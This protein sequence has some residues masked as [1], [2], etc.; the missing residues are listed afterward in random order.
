MIHMCKIKIFSLL[1]TGVTLLT[2]PSCSEE[3]AYG[4]TQDDSTYI[5]FGKPE[6]SLFGI[7]SRSGMENSLD[8]DFCV[9]GYCAPRDVANNKVTNWNNAQ[10][11]WV[12]KSP[13][14]IPNIF[15]KQRVERNGK[16][17]L[18]NGQL[19]SWETYAGLDPLQVKYTF[20]SY[21]PH[22]GGLFTM[23]TRND[24]SNEATA[25][26]MGVPVLTFNMPFRDTGSA[27]PT[28]RLNIG[29][30]KDAMIAAVFDRTRSQG[31]VDF[32]FEHLLS[33]FRFKINNYTNLLLQINRVELSGS[34]FRSADIDFSETTIARPKAT[35]EYSGTFVILD[36]DGTPQQIASQSESGDFLGASDE[37]S[38]EGVTLMLL[39][40]INADN[41]K[42][43]NYLGPGTAPTLVLDYTLYNEQNN[44]VV[45]DYKNVTTSFN[46]ANP[47]AGVRYTVNLNFV[48]NE[49]ILVFMPEGDSWE[50]DKDND[51]IIN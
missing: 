37:N 50:G 26:S 44:T 18:D 11:G 23:K 39:A 3:P 34:F 35:G 19:R 24:K 43:Y 33:A 36:G 47:S 38:H 14:V 20:I 42:N 31:P 27:D 48:G 2:L 8:G 13:Y 41:L 46:P 10:A 12:S 6:I 4:E 49:F 16:Y 17:A 29:D 25:E 32:R 28:V 7:S 5:L 1:L 22:D 45:A 51:I 15:C 30:I 40:D 21:Y 9:Y